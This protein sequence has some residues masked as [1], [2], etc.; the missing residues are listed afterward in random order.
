MR[1]YLIVFLVGA[2]LLA[3]GFTSTNTESA[4]EGG[5]L[6]DNS[7]LVYLIGGFLLMLVAWAMYDASSKKKR[8]IKKHEPHTH[9]KKL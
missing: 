3:Y 4:F 9:E 7:S 6:K 5:K 2:L 1:L 8:H